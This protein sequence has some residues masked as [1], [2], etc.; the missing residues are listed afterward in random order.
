VEHGDDYIITRGV[1]N[2][3]ALCTTSISITVLPFGNLVGGCAKEW[4]RISQRENSVQISLATEIPLLTEELKV[5]AHAGS[6][7]HLPFRVWVEP[8][9]QTR[10]GLFSAKIHILRYKTYANF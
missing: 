1:A 3:A 2:C 9:R 10:F 5:V 8:R 7:F 6:N 4:P